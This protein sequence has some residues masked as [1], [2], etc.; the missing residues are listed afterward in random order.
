MRNAP[1]SSDN[2][3][4]RSARSTPSKYRKAS[5][6]DTFTATP[7]AAG[8][9]GEDA[10]TV[11]ASKLLL[12]AGALLLGGT[13]GLLT[14]EPSVT[15]K[16]VDALYMTVATLTTIGYGDLVPTTLESKAFVVA[17]AICG[18]GLFGALLDTAAAWQQRVP[19]G[20]VGALAA[21]VG[22]GGAAFH[23]MEGWT[24]SDSLYFS[25]ITS[26]S[27]GYGDH[28]AF[29]SDLG[30][31]LLVAYALLSVGAMATVVNSLGDLVVAR[32]PLPGGVVSLG[33][34]LIAL[35]A[36]GLLAL[37]SAVAA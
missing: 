33:A 34:A 36:G 24:L 15:G 14:L 6:A 9:G 22:L 32:S 26:T 20:P 30:K 10:D 27:I 37:V 19:L 5:E 12:L 23:L 25:V 35:G 1:M 16:P 8:V 11:E 17:M 13:A 29:A 21:V 18:L 28:D 2:G 7:A 4:R 31:L 3:P